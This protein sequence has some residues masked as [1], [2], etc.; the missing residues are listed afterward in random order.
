MLYDNMLELSSSIILG[1]K[2]PGI[3]HYEY[4]WKKFKQNEIFSN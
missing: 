3:F 2:M 4:S 1:Q